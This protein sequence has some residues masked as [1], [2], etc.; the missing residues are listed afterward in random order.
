MCAAHEGGASGAEAP[1]AEAS[2]HRGEGT[3]RAPDQI[4]CL[5]PVARALS[6]IRGEQIGEAKTS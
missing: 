2:A 1:R 6:Q 3:Q 4:D 5:G